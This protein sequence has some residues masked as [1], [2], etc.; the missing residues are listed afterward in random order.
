MIQ[1]I[2]CYITSKKVSLRDFIHVINNLIIN[3]ENDYY[4]I[5]Y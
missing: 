4:Q 5:Y 1:N 2:F 3:K